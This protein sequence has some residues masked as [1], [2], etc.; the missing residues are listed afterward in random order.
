MKDFRKYNQFIFC[1][2]ILINILGL[3]KYIF[4]VAMFKFAFRYNMMT[5]PQLKK[6]ILEQVSTLK[7]LY[8]KRNQQNASF[9]E[10]VFP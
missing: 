9:I 4:Y 10:E 7:K 5:Q 2:N 1:A 6:N 3:I 8:Q